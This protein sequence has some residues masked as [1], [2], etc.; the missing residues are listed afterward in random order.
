MKFL[1]GFALVL[2][3][4][5]ASVN[6]GLD[7]VFEKY[8]EGLGD[9]FEDK[10]QDWLDNWE[11]SISTLLNKVNQAT[12]TALK[13]LFE[14]TNGDALIAKLKQWKNWTKTQRNQELENDEDLK[15]VLFSPSEKS[16][17]EAQR[18][19]SERAK[20]LYATRL[21][22]QNRETKSK[23]T[24][25]SSSDSASVREV[26]PYFPPKQ[27]TPRD[28]FLRIESDLDHGVK[29]SV[30]D[31]C[32]VLKPGKIGVYPPPPSHTPSLSQNLDTNQFNCTH[33][34][35]FLC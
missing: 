26:S 1:L 25:S 11:A 5:S 24:D 27:P 17:K 12:R 35:C 10:G 20:K 22:N 19:R 21:E 30:D 29:P 18:K 7:D 9:F 3:A 8:F 14:G 28:A 23:S 32:L 6:A 2:L 16:L 4:T 33:T 34:L 31:V 15:E 13:E